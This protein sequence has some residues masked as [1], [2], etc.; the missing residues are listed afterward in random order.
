[1]LLT[2]FQATLTRLAAIVY[3]GEYDDIKVSVS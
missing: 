1:M 3:N 2:V